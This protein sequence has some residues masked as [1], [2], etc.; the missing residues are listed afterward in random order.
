MSTFTELEADVYSVLRDTTKTFV[1]STEVKKWLNDGNLD[2]VARTGRLRKAVTGTTSS[3][4]TI[5]LP[6]DF[7]RLT[8]LY[9]YD[10]AVG[11][12]QPPTHAEDGQ[13]LWYQNSEQLPAT[14]IYRIFNGTIETYPAAI[15]AAYSLEYV[16]AP[17]VMS[18]GS[19]VPELPFEMHVKIVYYARAQAK[20]KEGEETEGD[21]YW[22]LYLDGIPSRG[23]DAG[24]RE[25]PGP[26][27]FL[28]VM[29]YWDNE[30]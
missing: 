29:T 12:S 11:L 30:L 21:R 8:S 23:P 16:Y 25:N 2:L 28:P 19:D 5:D 24:L 13:F 10:D 9:V 26:A 1:L 3:T 14:I 15:S 17:A 7:I 4:G 27:T 18:T 6:D 20:W 22:A